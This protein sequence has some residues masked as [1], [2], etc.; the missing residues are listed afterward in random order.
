MAHFEATRHRFA[1]DL[2]TLC[3][4]DYV[5]DGYIH[6]IGGNRDEDDGRVEELDE[7]E[8]S[9]LALS[10][11]QSV[12]HY[13]E[14]LLQD[15]LS[16]QYQFWQEKIS[17][18][19]TKGKEEIATLK[20]RNATSLKEIEQA[21]AAVDELE[22]NT[23]AMEKKIGAEKASVAKQEE[24]IQF[25][26]DL[27]KQLLAD[28]QRSPMAKE[29]IDKKLDEEQIR[30][31]KLKAEKQKRIE[32]L[33]KEVSLLMQELQP[34]PSPKC[35]IS[36]TKALASTPTS[37][38]PKASAVATASTAPLPAVTPTAGNA[39]TKAKAKAKAAK[40]KAAGLESAGPSSTS[41]S[42]LS[43]EVHPAPLLTISLDSSS[44]SEFDGEA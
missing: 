24:E 33:Q 19:D 13:Y 34:E 29:V 17:D 14:S 15:Q 30:F 42:S 43:L 5:G 38:T 18:L 7:S 36:E 26:H 2:Q 44:A 3:I 37:A 39:K 32:A 31:E 11:V 16:R 27:N 35:D 22:K 6:R 28:Q 23:R 4:W 41:D 1:I 12:S 9:D 40:A 10:K 25:L 8:A 20:R 21:K